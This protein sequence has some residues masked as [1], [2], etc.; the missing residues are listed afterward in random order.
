[1]NIEQ[2]LID[3]QVLQTGHFLLTSGLHS[4]KYFEK[5]RILENPNLVEM[6]ARQ[7]VQHFQNYNINIVCGPTTGGIIIAY[8][9]A[10]QMKTKCIFAETIANQS[11]RVIRRGFIIPPYARILVVD[12]ILTTGGSLQETIH[13]LQNFSAEIAGVAVFIDRSAN[14]IEF[15]QND[16]KIDL[17][18]CYKVS[19]QN[20]E[21]LDCPLCKN[22]IPLQSPGR[23]GKK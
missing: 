8:E 20:Y 3:Y 21:P 6:F 4:D 17:F 10:R 11:G 14:A 18:S 1:M 15:K 13:A 2:I 12:D 23:S 5:F 9:V 19:I 22:N 7:I 16:K